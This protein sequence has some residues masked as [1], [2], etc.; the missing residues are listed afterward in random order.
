MWR[1]HFGHTS[2]FT[3]KDIDFSLFL[4][5]QYFILMSQTLTRYWKII[6][7]STLAITGVYR[8]WSEDL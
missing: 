2:S 1:T 6:F 8:V 3:P 7:D 5:S 4:W